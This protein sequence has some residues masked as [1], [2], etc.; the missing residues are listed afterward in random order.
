MFDL[1]YDEYEFKICNI[2]SIKN[3]INSHRPRLNQ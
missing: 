2:I 3:E 1:R